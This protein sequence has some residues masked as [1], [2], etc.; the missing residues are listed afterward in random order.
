MKS[1]Y[2]FL[3]IITLICGGTLSANDPFYHPI[4]QINPGQLRYT[5]V[6][7]TTKKMKLEKNK[8]QFD[9]R[10]SSLSVVDRLVVVKGPKEI[11]Y[12]LIDGHHEYLACKALGDITLPIFVLE[13]L[14]ALSAKEFY[15]YAFENNFIYPVSISGELQYPKKGWFSWGELVDDPNRLFASI[16]A[17]HCVKKKDN[18]LVYFKNPN[19]TERPKFPLWIKRAWKKIEIAF[20]EFKI[21]NQL[22]KH[23]IHYQ[24]EMGANPNSL[25]VEALIEKARNILTQ[26]PVGNLELL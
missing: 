5:K 1:V 6:N 17:L 16:S 18:S 23:G 20:I 26:D 21:A 9:H 15:A 8:Q 22:Y 19:A 12:V 11:G 3:F 4:D 14:S 7:V 2:R 24:Y 25:E 13:D 10:H